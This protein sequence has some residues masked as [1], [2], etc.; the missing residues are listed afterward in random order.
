MRR[1][2]IL[3]TGL[4]YFVYGALVFAVL[5]FYVLTPLV[6]RFTVLAETNKRAS[7]TI[8]QETGE[9]GEDG[10]AKGQTTVQTGDVDLGLAADNQVNQNQAQSEEATTTPQEPDP[11]GAGDQASTTATSTPQD[12]IN[13]FAA[14]TTSPEFPGSTGTPES[15]GSGTESFSNTNQAEVGNSLGANATTGENV[16]TGGEDSVVGTGNIGADSQTSNQGNI[17]DTE[18][19]CGPACASGTASTTQTS[20]TNQNQASTTNQTKIKGVSGANTIAS[21]GTSTIMT[22]NINILNIILNFLNNNFFGQGKEFFVNILDYFAGDIDLSGYDQ[23]VELPAGSGSAAI[24]NSSTST[25]A[26]QVDISAL[27]GANTIASGTGSSLIQTGDIDIGN[28]LFNFVNNNVTGSNWFFAVVNVFD[29]LEG[30]VL[31]P[32]WNKGGGEAMHDILN[33]PEFASSSAKENFLLTNTNQS[34]TLNQV[35]VDA[36]TGANRIASS[37]GDAAITTGDA[38]V[39]THAFNIINYNYTGNKWRL[40]RINVFG[41]WQGIIEGLPDGYDY[42]QD[43]YGITVYQTPEAAGQCD[44][45]DYAVNNDNYASTT[46]QINIEADTGGNSILHSG[47]DAAIE[48]GDIN[49]SNNLLNF[50]NSNFT[51]NDWEFSMVN[52]FGEWQGNLSFGRPELWVTR[53]AS[54]QGKVGPGEYI[55]VNFLFGNNGDAKATDVRLNENYAGKYLQASQTGDGANGQGKVVWDIGDLPPNSQGSLSYRIKVKEDI[56]AGNSQAENVATIEAQQEDR[57]DSNNRATDRFSLRGGSSSDSGF[58]IAGNISAHPGLRVIKTNDAEGELGPGDKVD[59]RISIENTGEEDLY[60]VLV[61]DVLRQMETEE[62]VTRNFWDLGTVKA[63]E[64]IYID[65]TVQ[66]GKQITSGTY[67][68]EVTVEGYDES[69]GGYIPTVASSKIKVV[70]DTAEPE[71]VLGPQLTLGYI[72]RQD[73]AKPGG[74]AKYELL[75]TNNGDQTATSVVVKQV[76]SREL[77]FV[78]GKKDG[79]VWQVGELKPGKVEN[80][81]FEVSVDTGTLSGRYGLSAFV[82]AAG[83]DKV[84]QDI[85]LEVRAAEG[86]DASGSVETREDKGQKNGSVSVGQTQAQADYL[87]GSLPVVEETE[88]ESAASRPQGGGIKVKSANAQTPEPE[89][90]AKPM[91]GTGF[92]WFFWAKF[93]ILLFVIY[94]IL[95]Y[96]SDFAK[97]QSDA[98]RS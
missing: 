70:N 26:N 48:T 88:E 66:I 17:N 74:L 86:A 59:F 13:P 32:A 85:E 35:A 27:T 92:D 20:V 47:G 81:P 95:I 40:L 77:E 16:I 64:Q 19:P 93:F 84:F 24:D 82:E 42:F 9:D 34:D 3:P 72:A 25:L 89:S 10:Q 68:N 30:D 5:A 23:D 56:P 73:F 50:I 75:I 12:P 80:F 90:S 98:D 15:T 1:K 54:K 76:S 97:D 53:S 43:E 6:P 49:V 55:T 94:V 46:N 91:P 2:K 29:I 18:V 52:V 4:N 28:H 78:N 63:G 33:S 96:V 21:S 87:K 44:N 39:R 57:D 51:G 60:E 45:C 36:D 37:S 11:A 8:G 31:L 79:L 41:D 71:G 67:L 62:E 83:A 69:S 61:L 38:V 58:R 65:Y 22:G 7:T 14:T